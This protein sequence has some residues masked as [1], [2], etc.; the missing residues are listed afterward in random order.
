M[1]SLR[2]QSLYTQPKPKWTSSLSVPQW[3]HS[4]FF[5]FP[6]H[7][8]IEDVALQGTKF[9]AGASACLQ[10]AWPKVQQMLKSKVL[11]D[12]AIPFLG[13]YP[14]KTIIQKDMCTPIFIVLTANKT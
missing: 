2:K 10:T 11:Y 14:D 4:G 9:Y 13:K 1:N 12:S 8:F 5:F 6:P 7:S 3:Y